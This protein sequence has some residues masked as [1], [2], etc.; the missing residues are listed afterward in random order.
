MLRETAYA[1]SRAYA[2]AK[3]YG[4]QLA[5]G[6]DTL[7]D[8]KLALPQVAQ[9]AKMVRWFEPAEVL[10]MATADNARLLELSGLRNPYPGKTK[11]SG[12]RIAGLAMAY[13]L[14]D[15]AQPRWC[16][17]NAI[18]PSGVRLSS[19]RSPANGSTIS[20]VPSSSSAWKIWR[21][22]PTGSPMSC[23]QSNIVTRS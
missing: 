5:W 2:L 13:K 4:I 15:A 8:A 7:F 10:K 23:R 12:S 16:C 22:A 14:L 21:P 17:V 6:T 18:L 1:V 11:G 9:L 19:R 20:Q 3:Q